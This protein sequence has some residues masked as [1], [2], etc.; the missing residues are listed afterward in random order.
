MFKV[1]IAGSR[2]FSN[3][4]LMAKKLDNI[5][6]RKTTVEIVSGGARGAD[7]YG[8]MYA[9]AKGHALKRFPA[10]WNKYGRSAGYRRNEQM[11]QYADALVAFWDGQSRGTFHMIN[12][13]K[14]YGLQIRVIRY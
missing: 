14:Q 7:Y 11:A 9:K 13:A 6:S 12:L 1:I 8:E 3:Y 2:G 5:L 4:E 10:E